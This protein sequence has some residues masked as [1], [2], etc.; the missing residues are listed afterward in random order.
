MN[1]IRL[2]KKALLGLLILAS[3]SSLIGCTQATKSLTEEQKT[4]IRNTI[5]LYETE[6]NED[7]K[8]LGSLLEKNIA[9]FDQKDK[10]DMIQAY[11]TNHYSIGS[12][13]ADKLMTI[14]YEL[15]DVIEEYGVD[16]YNSS[17]YKKIPD[18]HGTVRGF[19]LELKEKGFALK[20]ESDVSDFYITVDLESVLNKFG[21][22]MSKS[23]KAYTEFAVYEMQSNDT[24]DEE[25][26]EFDL[27]EICNRITK[28]ENGLKIDKEQNYQYAEKWTNLMEDYY[29]ILFGVDHD[30]FVSS[31]YIKQSIIDKYEELA[32]THK[33]T[34]IE[35][36]INQVLS[37][38]SENG[39]RFD[40]VTRSKIKILIQDS[41]YTK[42]IKNAIAMNNPSTLVDETIVDNPVDT[43]DTTETT[44][45]EEVE[46]VQEETETE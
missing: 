32:K 29:F 21:S 44:D 19:L 28:L 34:D 14:G 38:L 9:H 16:V 3:S 45:K 22:H 7:I 43:T 23:L 25:K 27:D 2:N 20:S 40:E 10:D 36:N 26:N 31:E 13:L 5:L 39:N 33:G 11:I 17:T 37:V 41:I 42:E 24:F 15:E 35:K 12:D 8:E 46:Q 1:K 30:Y 18:S 6:G 4:E